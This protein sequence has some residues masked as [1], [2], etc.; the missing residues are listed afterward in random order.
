MRNADKICNLHNR[1][2]NKVLFAKNSTTRELAGVPGDN[3]LWRKEFFFFFSTFFSLL[4]TM[5][6]EKLLPLDS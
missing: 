3:G 6:V 4:D 5:I 1:I 2:S